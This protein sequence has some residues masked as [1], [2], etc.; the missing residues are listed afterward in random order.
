[1][2]TEDGKQE[3]N[4]DW[5]NMQVCQCWLGHTGWIDIL[6]YWLNIYYYS[7][8]CYESRYAQRFNLPYT[9]DYELTVICERL[10]VLMRAKYETGSRRMDRPNNVDNVDP[11]DV[12]Q[13]RFRFRFSCSL[14]ED[15]F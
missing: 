5:P 10:P 8:Y 4:L 7:N 15:S 11:L 2:R 14:L 9:L 3:I 1:M 13:V 6:L 12:D